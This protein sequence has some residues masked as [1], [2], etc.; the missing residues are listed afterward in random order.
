ME[1]TEHVHFWE[2]G[3]MRSALFKSFLYDGAV[4]TPHLVK[5]TEKRLA[6]DVADPPMLESTNSTRR[7]RNWPLERCRRRL[8]T[9]KPRLFGCS[10]APCRLRQLIATSA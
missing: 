8:T 10:R 3:G 4:R 7:T 1:N 5:D 2:C 9:V 6:G